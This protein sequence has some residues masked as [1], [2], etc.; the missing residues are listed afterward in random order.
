MQTTKMFIVELKN[1]YP[2]VCITSHLSPEGNV[3]LKKGA[4]NFFSKK[5]FGSPLT[6][7]IVFSKSD[8]ILLGRYGHFK[9]IG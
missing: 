1:I 6:M 7:K 5:K 2:T 3:S 8:L 4:G 9:F